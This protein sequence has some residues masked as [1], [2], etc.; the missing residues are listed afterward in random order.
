MINHFICLH[1]FCLPPYL[2]LCRFCSS[3][4]THRLLLLTSVNSAA[5]GLTEY[6]VC[7]V[8]KWT[9]NW[10]YNLQSLF[11]NLVTF[12]DEVSHMEGKCSS[13]HPPISFSIQAKWFGI[14]TNSRNWNVS[15]VTDK[16]SH[17]RQNRIG[18]WPCQHRF[19]YLHHRRRNRRGGG[20]PPHLSVKRLWIS[21]IHII[22][23]RSWVLQLPHFLHASSTTVHAKNQLG[24]RLLH[25]M[26]CLP[27]LFCLQLQMKYRGMMVNRPAHMY[28]VDS[29]QLEGWRLYYKVNYTA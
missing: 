13:G 15:V 21:L 25:I 2:E 6:A 9:W 14:I 8:F 27:Y 11:L 3:S 29:D 17:M 20:A 10:L 12:P 22:Y 23:I 16:L 24:P 18:R 1:S 28:L 5:C 4:S 26:L 19:F 7:A